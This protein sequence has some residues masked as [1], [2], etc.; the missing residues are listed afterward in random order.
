MHRRF[1]FTIFFL[2]SGS[3]LTA[4][5]ADRPLDFGR[6]VLPIL[7]NKC[8]TCHGPDAK[9]DALRLD[10]LEGATSDRGGYK[11][12]DLVAPEKSAVLARLHDKEDPMPPVDAEKQLTE[13]E[14]LVL[15][16]WVREGGQ[17]AEHWAFISP[18]KSEKKTEID[19]FIQEGM[20]KQSADFAPEA[21]RRTL[22]RRA[23][24]TLTGLPPEPEQLEAFLAD[25]SEDAYETLV[26][27]LLGSSRYGEHQARYW[28]DAVR[29]GDTHGLHLDN[30]RGI[31]PYRDWVVR[32]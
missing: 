5:A 13:V 20:E 21:D 14:R 7:S 12:I 30:R 4:Q 32:A 23:A 28:L 15:D 19:G 27:V 16:Q 10:S 22:A 11:A 25:K 2:C 26:D 18:A 29:Y 3:L 17:Y 9:K 1:H 24:F 31:Y 8:F 6:E